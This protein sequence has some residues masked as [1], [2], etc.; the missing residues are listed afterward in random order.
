M[1]QESKV[2]CAKAFNRLQLEVP[3]VPGKPVVARSFVSISGYFQAKWPVVLRYLAFQVVVARVASPATI[4]GTKVRLLACLVATR[5]EP[6]GRDWPRPG[7]QLY[8]LDS[9]RSS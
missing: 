5:P 8:G 9:R 6:P 7:A 3:G 4:V 2:C 1:V